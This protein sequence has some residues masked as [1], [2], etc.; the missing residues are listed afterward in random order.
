MK[1]YVIWS[2]GRKFGPAD[3]PTLI[4]WAQEGRLNRETMVE[5]AETGQQGRARDIQGMTWPTMAPATDMGGGDPTLKAGEKPLA[6]PST[7]HVPGQPKPY[8]A[9]QPEP[10]VAGQPQ[11][12]AQDPLGQPQQ[13]QQQQPSHYDSA[14]Q[15]TQGPGQSSQ[16]QNPPAPGSPYPRDAGYDKHLDDGSQKLVTNAW[17]MVLLGVLPC[18]GI[19]IVPFGMYSASRALRMGNVNAKTPLTIGWVVLGLQVITY[20]IF[21]VPGIIAYF[22]A[23]KS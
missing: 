3:I 12:S 14:R 21:V 22:A 20:A 19:V 2:D 4:Q 8:I 10:Y 6:T 9:G 15:P 5:N 23:A 13:P 16:Y 7:I 1:F 11:Q 18:C 17:V